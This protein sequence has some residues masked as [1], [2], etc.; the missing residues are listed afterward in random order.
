[1]G[2][3]SVHSA[4]VPLRVLQG[5]TDECHTTRGHTVP[6]VHAHIATHLPQGSGRENCGYGA[7]TGY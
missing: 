2:H 7:R 4:V 3:Y 5:G 6:L 1:M